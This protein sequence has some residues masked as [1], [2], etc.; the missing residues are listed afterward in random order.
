MGRLQGRR[1]AGQEGRQ[2]RRRQGDGEHPAVDGYF[3]QARDTPGIERYECVE[4][5]CGEDQ[6]EPGAE[7]SQHERFRQDQAQDP[8]A[9][10]AERGANG[11]FASAPR[12]PRQQQVGQVHAG[13]TEKKPDGAQQDPQGAA[14]VVAGDPGARRE[15]REP[16]P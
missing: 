12:G 11:D 16:H 10:G 13:D 7:Q 1:Q 6:A 2:Q 5:P 3:S 4:H 14:Q 8:H 15:H 9:A